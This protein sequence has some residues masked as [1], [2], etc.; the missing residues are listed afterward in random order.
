M[1][2][3]RTV[4]ASVV[5]LG[6]ARP[7]ERPEEEILAGKIAALEAVGWSPFVVRPSARRRW[8]WSEEDNDWMP[9]I[10]QT[11]QS[12][13]LV[14][15]DRSRGV[16]RRLLMLDEVSSNTRYASAGV[17]E[18]G[19]G[20]Q[21][22]TWFDGELVGVQSHPVPTTG[23]IP[24][25]EGFDPTAW[26]DR[27]FLFPE[28]SA[29]LR[30]RLL[31]EDPRLVARFADHD[32]GGVYALE[33]WANGNDGACRLARTLVRVDAGGL[34]RTDRLPAAVPADQELLLYEELELTFGF[35]RRGAVGGLTSRGVVQGPVHRDSWPWVSWFPSLPDTAPNEQEDPC[36]ETTC[37]E[38][39]GWGFSGSEVS[40]A[41]A[42]DALEGGWD[43]LDDIPS[44][45]DGWGE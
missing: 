15:S 27:T 24:P 23:Q 39:M 7:P 13:R 25:E 34:A 37:V 4:M 44:C 33:L 28:G 26:L 1:R 42:L 22:E 43:S 11:P 18:P 32:G 35:D 30:Q 20:W 9:W 45:L 12:V 29:A 3:W 38:V 17:L 36:G 40:A 41:V 6:C 19:V 5:L 2:G 31:D 8:V 10:S 21:L 16:E 14:V